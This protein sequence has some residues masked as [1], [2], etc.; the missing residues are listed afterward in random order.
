[1]DVSQ[2]N[3]SQDLTPIGASL[4]GCEIYTFLSESVID[5]SS[6]EIVRNLFLNR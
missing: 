3:L 6:T 4:G 5:S 1:M 2:A